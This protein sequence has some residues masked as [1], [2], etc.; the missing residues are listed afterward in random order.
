MKK[1]IIIALAGAMVML[2]SCGRNP[3]A[4]NEI[5]TNHILVTTTAVGRTAYSRDIHSFGIVS[6]ENE[7]RFSFKTSGIINRLSIKEGERFYKGQVLAELE[8]TEV[9]AQISNARENYGKAERDYRRMENL[10][11]DSVASAEQLQNAKT[12]LTIAGEALQVAQYNNE[13]SVIKAPSGGVVTKR[14]FN[15]GEIVN[16]GTTVIAASIDGDAGM[17][18]KVGLPVD[19]WKNI[20]EGDRATIRCEAY[21]DLPFSGS[22]YTIAQSADLVTGLYP[23]EI[24]LNAGDELVTVGMFA[25]VTIHPLKEMEY[26]TVPVSCLTDADNRNVSVYIPDNHLVRKIA[27]DVSFIEHGTAYISKGLEGVQQV[28]HEGA[29]F[30]NEKSIVVYK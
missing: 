22:V 24:K 19:E 26:F 5:N 8:M 17:I 10:H 18:V 14:F 30:L 16:V 3:K 7:Q 12:L 25:E 21:P 23:V 1:T 6:T 20:A 29:G 27:V 4:N 13:Y 2:G 9:N 28:I 11:R 15:T